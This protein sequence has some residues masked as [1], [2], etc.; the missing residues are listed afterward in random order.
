MSNVNYLADVMTAEAELTEQLVEVMREQQAALVNTDSACVVRTTEQQQELLLP[1]EGFE[2]ERMR[3]TRELW[4]EL[5]PQTHDHHDAVPLSSLIAR[6]EEDDAA[7]IAN[8][9]RRLRAAVEQMVTLKQ[10]NEYLIEHSRKLVRETMKIV[11]NDY[12]RQLVDQKI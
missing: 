6:L 12:S 4:S 9:G 1:I 3:V 5:A 11:T 8:A 7:T 2:Q 10:A